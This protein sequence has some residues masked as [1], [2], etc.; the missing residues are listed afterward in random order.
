MIIHNL[1]QGS[2]EWHAYRANHFNSSDAPA[3]LGASSYRSRTELLDQR[4]TGLSAEV[5]A[6]TQY[7]FDK[8][9]E[10]E[11]RARPLAEK[12]VGED[13]YPVT[14]SDGKYSA[15]FDGLTLL[16]DV[17]FEHKMLNERIRAALSVPGATANDLPLEY[18]IQMEQ[19]CMVSGCEKVLFMASTWEGDNLIEEMHAWYTPDPELRQQIIHGW[20]QFEA[21]LLSHTPVVQ[22][23]KPQGTAPESLPALRIELVGQVANTNLPAF[24]EVA[25]A[26][27]SEINTNLVTD[28]DFASAEKTVKW[29][30][31]VETR[32]DSAKQHALSQTSTIEELFRTINEISELTRQKRLTLEKLV[33]T[34]KE[35]IRLNIVN[36]AAANWEEFKNQI[37]QDLGIAAQF[38]APAIAAAVKGKRT[39]ASMQDAANTELANAKAAAN[40]LALQVGKNLKAFEVATE[41]HAALFFDKAELVQK[42]AEVMIALIEQ[43]ISKAQADEAERNRIKAENDAKQA[44]S[45]PVT[46]LPAPPASKQDTRVAAPTRSGATKALSV[47]RPSEAEIIDLL[48]TH[49]R[50]D[51][52]TVREWLCEMSVSNSAL[53]EQN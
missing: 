50:V 13:L 31:D 49:Y 41:H 32:L 37:T 9:H 28:E 4:A 33:K 38:T 24:K 16:N 47:T 46:A 48:A 3:M 25:L 39:V 29:C 7:I 2:P 12:I 34:Q 8:G 27:L 40:Q 43:R 42:P 51:Q 18:R 44:P 11:A 6:G 10:F 35:S 23:V 20:E 52:S 36:K 22:A 45:Q 26:V 30:A 15:S 14:G 53:L 5:S 1:I 17:A 19:Q 21:D